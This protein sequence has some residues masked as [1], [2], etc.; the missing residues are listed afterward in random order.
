MDYLLDISMATVFIG[1][2]VG[3]LVGL[4]GIGGG[5]LMTPI[6]ILFLGIRPTIAV[7]T[8]L[9]FGAI[10]KVFGSFIHYRQK[11]VNLSIVFF[12]ALGSVP[13]SLLGVYIISAI[14]KHYGSFVDAFVMKTLGIT[15]IIVAIT[16]VLRVIFPSSQARNDENFLTNYTIRQKGLTILLGGVVG[17]LVGLTSVG[18]GSLIVP[19]LLALFPKLSSKNIVGTDVFHAAILVSV[20]GI[21]HLGNGNVQLPVVV[22][23]LVGSLPGVYLGSRMNMKVSERVLR[24]VLASMLMLT[25]LKLI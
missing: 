10:T 5:S 9:I 21:A 11:S 17:F 15:L 8:D 4:T 23:L 20:A 22:S 7:G 6:M 16:M 18:S 25:G 13:C 1:F 2:S 19:V 12:L 3:F 14:K 24:P